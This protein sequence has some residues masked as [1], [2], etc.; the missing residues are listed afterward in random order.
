MTSHSVRAGIL[1]CMVLFVSF[2]CIPGCIEIGDEGAAQEGVTPHPTATSGPLIPG[3]DPGFTPQGS[4]ITPAPTSGSVA[5]AVT[6]P[7]SAAVTPFYRTHIPDNTSLVRPNDM[8]TAAFFSGTY[9][10]LYNNVALVATV[11]Q[12]PF[13]IEFWNSAYSNNPNDAI[14]VI[15]VRDPATGEVIIEDGYNGQYSSESYKRIVIRD[16]GQFHVNIY[17]VRSK[18]TVKLRGGVDESAAEP[19]G[20]MDSPIVYEQE[21]SEEEVW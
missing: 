7:P 18:V 9:D 14:M 1:L 15:T 19:Y 16:S 11:D 17:G 20:Q 8:P 12:A 21:Y 3:S 2:S 10:L 6:I 4:S 13:V 5:P